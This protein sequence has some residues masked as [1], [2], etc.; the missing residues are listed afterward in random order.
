MAAGIGSSGA[1]PATGANRTRRTRTWLLAVIVIAAILLPGV[2][3]AQDISV[4][5]GDDTTLTERAVQLIGLIT[6]SRLRRRS[7]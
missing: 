7:W 6:I 2:V 1:S 4:D 3:L 5:F